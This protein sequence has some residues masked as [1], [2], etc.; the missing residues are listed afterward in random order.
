VAGLHIFK[1][2]YQQ[3]KARERDGECNELEDEQDVNQSPNPVSSCLW[4]PLKMSLLTN[5][6]IEI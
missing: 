6:W 5:Q 4:T 1:L 2:V 3:E